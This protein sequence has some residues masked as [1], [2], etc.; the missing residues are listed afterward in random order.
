[1]EVKDSFYYDETSPSCLRWAEN[2]YS[3]K[4]NSWLSRKI[5]DVAGSLNKQGYWRLNLN[6]KSYLAHRVIWQLSNGEIPEGFVVDHIDKNPSNN[7]LENLRMVPIA[8]NSRNSS[9]YSTNTTGVNGV[10]YSEQPERSPRY[11]AHWRDGDRGRTKS[12]L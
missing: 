10:I 8:V 5:G 7:R 6:G 9:L 12:F 2:R 4:N 3:A 11:I 1:V